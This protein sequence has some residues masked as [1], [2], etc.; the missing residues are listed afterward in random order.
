MQPANLARFL[1]VQ[2][3]RVRTGVSLSLE[4]VM[5]ESL[6]EVLFHEGG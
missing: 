5:S 1:T 6:L 4:S 3:R 2:I